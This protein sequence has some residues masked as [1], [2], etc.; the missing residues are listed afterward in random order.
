M[1][2]AKPDLGFTKPSHDST[3]AAVLLTLTYAD[4]FAYPLTPAEVFQ[5]LIGLRTERADVERALAESPQLRGRI[6][7]VDGFI[8][9]PQRECL[10][11]IRAARHA[12]AQR[13]MPRARFYARLIAHFPY[14]R[15]IALTGSLAM[16]NAADHDI[17][18]LIVTRPG[19]L[20]LV[21]G[22]AVALVRLARLRG[23]RLCPNFLLAETALAI[24]EQNLY[25]AHEIVQM[26]PLYGFG[27]YRRMRLA[28]AWALAYLC[29][30]GEARI[31]SAEIR[32]DRVGAMLKRLC[33]RLL[34]GKIGNRLER[35]EMSRKVAKLSA[36]VPAADGEARFSADVCRGFLDGHGR[37][38][39]SAFL[40]RTQASNATQSRPV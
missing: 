9:L 35:W 21:R 5:Y 20:W 27:V 32:L 24:P 33:E 31:V 4:L 3:A 17:D 18:L 36:Q 40:E 8:T 38:V 34:E 12:A 15:M 22:F 19:R 37:R 30:A 29:N 6:A 16:E 39:L 10:V 1:I 14:V 7:R 26:I 13:Q 11:E 23:D 25:Q 28:N 2:N